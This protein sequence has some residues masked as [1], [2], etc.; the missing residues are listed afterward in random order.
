MNQYQ[1]IFM[2]V[3]VNFPDTWGFRY[4]GNRKSI[5]AIPST[6]QSSFEDLPSEGAPQK[7]LVTSFTPHK[8]GSPILGGVF[9]IVALYRPYGVDFESEI[10]SDSSEISRHFG[11]HQIAGNYARYLHIEKQGEGYIRYLRCHYW[12][13]QL[14]I[15]LACI[16]SGSSLEQFNEAL[17][18]VESVQKI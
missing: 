15:W 16:A 8:K 5:S 9:E 2:G 17:D 12:Q 6:H 1:N 14:E 4:W 7:V 11:E 10:P 3:G 18:I 13:Y